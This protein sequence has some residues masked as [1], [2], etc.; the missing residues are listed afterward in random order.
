M[1]NLLLVSPPFTQLNTPYPATA[2]LKGYL[3]TQGISSHQMDLGIETILQLF[4]QDGLRRLFDVATPHMLTASANAHRIYSLS[5]SYIHTIDPVISFLQDEDPS[6][7]YFICGR[8][9]L[10]ES[11]KFEQLEDIEWAFGTMGIRDKARHIATLYLEDLSD[12]ISEVVDPHFGFS[13]YAERL[14][15]SARSFDE[16]YAELRQTTGFIA[17][18]MVSIF[19]E[20]ISASNP[21]VVCLSVPFPGNLFAALKCGQWIKQYHPQIKVVMGG[22]YPNTELRSLSDPR[23]FEFVDF[24]CLDDGETLSLIHI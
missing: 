16:L 22:G 13:R 3:N 20:K 14:A 8:N 12:F 5:E 2:Y 17:G 9:F 21:D 24:I 19:E 18:I 10:P 7:A 23:V 1:N 4:S 6:L 15:M 11:S